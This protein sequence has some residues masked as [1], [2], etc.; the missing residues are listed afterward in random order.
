MIVPQ[1]GKRKEKAE[2]Y[3]TTTKKIKKYKL[4]KK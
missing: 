1:K 4:I 2:R 3:Q